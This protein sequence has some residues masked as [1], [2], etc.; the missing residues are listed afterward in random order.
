MAQVDVKILDRDY[1]LSVSDD[2]RPRLLQAVELVDE[3][4]RT[5]RD[6]GKISGH[7]RIAVMAALQIAHDL[8]AAPGGT[9]ADAESSRRIR[10]LS[11]E[12]DT[13]VKR[14]EKLF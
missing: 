1:R 9:R 5:I 7:D 11:E 12:I 2:D 3:R 4:M 6:G 13:E 14:Q 10:K 8:L